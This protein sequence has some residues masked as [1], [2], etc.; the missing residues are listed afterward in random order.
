MD[1]GV[2]SRGMNVA[3]DR[4]AGPGGPRQYRF[5]SECGGEPLEGS[6]NGE[7]ETDLDFKNAVPK[8]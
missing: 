2:L 5:Y 6:D 1:E 4:T 7:T 8:K 3:G